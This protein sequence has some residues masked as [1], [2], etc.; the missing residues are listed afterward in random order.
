MNRVQ[1]RG[2]DGGHHRA[3]VLVGG[4]SLPGAHHHQLAPEGLESLSSRSGRD[5]PI[6]D[7]I[8]TREGWSIH[9]QDV[10]GGLLGAHVSQVQVVGAGPAN[11]VS[12]SH[13][14]DLVEAA[15]LHAGRPGQGTPLEAGPGG[16]ETG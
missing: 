10:V 8:P 13:R 4:L 9:A 1:P 16:T 15:C 3:D 7:H 2:L 5:A 14:V 11:Q 12:G 6:F